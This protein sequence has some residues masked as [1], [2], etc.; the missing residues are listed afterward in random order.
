MMKFFL[1]GMGG[2][3]ALRRHTHWSCVFPVAALV[4]W[5]GASDSGGMTALQFQWMQLSRLRGGLRR[6]SV[7]AAF[8]RPGRRLPK[9]AFMLS[10][11]K[12]TM[13]RIS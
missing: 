13:G 7:Q 1:R 5:E 2:A 4:R 6:A 8:V 11:P 9:T 12:K 3:L 10:S